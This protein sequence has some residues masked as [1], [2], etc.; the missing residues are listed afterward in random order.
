MTRIWMMASSPRYKKFRM[1]QQGLC[2]AGLVYSRACVQQGLCTGFAYSR[3]CVQQGLC[4]AGPVYSRACVQQ[5]LCTAPLKAHS[6]QVKGS[7]I[8]SLQMYF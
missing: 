2:T 7:I 8:M 3:A 6:A 1:Q 4:T 5:G